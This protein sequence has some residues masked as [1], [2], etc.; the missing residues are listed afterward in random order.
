MWSEHVTLQE[1]YH[2]EEVLKRLSLDPL[3]NIQ[4]EEKTIYIPLMMDGE[5]IVVRV[6]AVGT[7]EEPEFW[8]SSQSGEQERVIKRIRSI[9]Q[10]NESLSH[11]QSHFQQTS[12]QSLFEKFAYT[13]LILEFDY[14]TCLLRCII[15]QQVHLKF[16]TA[17]TEQFVKTYGTEKNGV[18]FFPTPEKVASISPEELRNQKFSQRKAEYI[19]GLAKLI[20][21][22]QLNLHELEN[23]SN[24]E[25]ASR[26]LPVRGIGAWTVQNFLLFGLGRQNMFPKADIGIQRALQQM[27]QLERKP[28]DSFLEKIQQECNPYCSYAALYL[29]KSIE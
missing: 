18:Y 4:L 21:N 28:D 7:F 9:F 23:M 5:H 6:Q 27:F 16:A 15:H 26:L 20:V 10:W 2:F 22:G 19:V 12:L 17:L 25:V 29:W 14:F 8:V 24:E 1:P 11:I 3:H 13:P